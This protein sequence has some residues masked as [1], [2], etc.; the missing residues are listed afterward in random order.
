MLS[1]Y[2]SAQVS[3]FTAM[4]SKDPSVVKSF[5]DANP[6]H[7]KTPELKQKLLSMGYAGN[8][9]VAKPTVTKLT[10]KKLEKNI[11]KSKT[12]EDAKKTANL[13]THLF[14]DD[15]KS[16]ETILQIVNKSSC[17]LIVKIS[18]KKFYN[19]TVSPKNQNY[20]LIEKGKYTIS[21][22]ICDAKYS[23]SKTINSSTVISLNGGAK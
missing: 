22:S 14:Q 6:K 7:P 1:V 23:S 21:T 9:E 15:P 3:V 13:L 2:F 5:I 20:L 18:G 19:L 17:N 12:S 16:K 10:P 4:S 8:S 11:D